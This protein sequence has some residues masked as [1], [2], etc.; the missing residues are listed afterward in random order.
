MVYKGATYI[1]V[2]TVLSEI[3]MVMLNGIREIRTPRDC[4]V[5]FTR[6]DVELGGNHLAVESKFIVSMKNKS[7]F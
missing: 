1:R 7:D 2:F 5:H 3:C 4:R 6:E